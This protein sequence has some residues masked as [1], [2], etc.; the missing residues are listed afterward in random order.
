MM[1]TGKWSPFLY[2]LFNLGS[3][4][5]CWGG[6]WARQAGSWQCW[7]RPCTW[8]ETAERK[9]SPSPR[10]T[11]SSMGCIMNFHVLWWNNTSSK[12]SFSICPAI[13]ISSWLPFLLTLQKALRILR[14]PLLLKFPSGN[15]SFAFHCSVPLCTHCL[16]W[17]FQHTVA[18]S[19]FWLCFFLH[20]LEQ[21]QLG[22]LYSTVSLQNYTASP[23]GRNPFLLSIT[24]LFALP[25]LSH[26]WSQLNIHY[27][28][29]GSSPPSCF[30]LIMSLFQVVSMCLSYNIN[31]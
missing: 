22:Y 28:K 25:L 24:V 5:P 20:V 12:G 26:K 3:S 2:K 10:P 27:W 29:I 4:P 11:G 6:Q 16:N 18:P 15:K 21:G 7:G 23:W 14:R 13:P 17:A 31:D 1:L 19:H 30:F 8:L 9:Q